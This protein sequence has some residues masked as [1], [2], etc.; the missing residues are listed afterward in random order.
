MLLQSKK[1]KKKYFSNFSIRRYTNGLATQSLRVHQHN[2]S[3]LMAAGL[4][5][6]HPLLF[7]ICI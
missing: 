4:S 2:S 5:L 6:I 1:M 3:I 7:K